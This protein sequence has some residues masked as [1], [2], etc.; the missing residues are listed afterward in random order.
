[1]HTDE[2]HSDGRIFAGLLLNKTIQ[3]AIL[4]VIEHLELSMKGQKDA[5][6]NE[7][8]L[9]T[10]DELT[11]HFELISLD[12]CKFEKSHYIG[13]IIEHTARIIYADP[14]KGLVYVQVESESYDP[15]SS[16]EGNKTSLDPFEEKEN[17]LLNLTYKIDR[18]V[19]LKQIMPKS[20]SESLLYLQGKRMIDAM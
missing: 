5:D 11:E 15:A 20:Y 6:G 14:K 10:A 19:N 16:M 4:S 13:E 17:N 9:M 7:I 3:V 18:G 8:P 1:M 12:I 2:S